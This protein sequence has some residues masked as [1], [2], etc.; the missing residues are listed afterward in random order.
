MKFILLLS[1][2]A[3]F[4][5]LGDATSNKRPLDISAPDRVVRSRQMEDGNAKYGLLSDAEIAALYS[6]ISNFNDPTPDAWNAP[7]N[8]PTLEHSSESSQRQAILKQYISQYENNALDSTLYDAHDD[9]T[10]HGYKSDST[11]FEDDYFNVIL[12]STPPP[13][14]RAAPSSSDGDQGI[15]NARNLGLD[16][17]LAD[18]Y[19][20]REQKFGTRNRDS[21]DSG[22][23]RRAAPIDQTK[24]NTPSHGATTPA[25]SSKGSAT[26]AAHKSKAASQSKLDKSTG[27]H[28]RGPATASAA[29]KG[30]K[31]SAVHQAIPSATTGNTK[32]MSPS[33]KAPKPSHAANAP[34]ARV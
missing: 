25:T 23:Y 17:T 21:S 1:I 6:D 19:P 13:S 30:S 10:S 18:E 16:F 27:S 14:P 26:I 12:D 4:P 7:Q 31:N 20:T 9:S 29:S 5:V 8:R 28:A 11:G 32:S 34:G 33:K 2:V 24:S 3:A 22:L 15:A